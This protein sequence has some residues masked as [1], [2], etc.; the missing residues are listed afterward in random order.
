LQFALSGN[1]AD[2][3]PSL[4][5]MLYVGVSAGSIATTPCHCDVDWDLQWVPPVSDMALRG[6]RAI[7]LVDFA[8]WVHLDNPD[9]M[10]EDNSMA[11]IERWAAGVPMSNHAID[12]ATALKVSGATVEVVSEGHWRLFTFTASTD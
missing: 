7:G 6:E 9:P 8:L 4:E 2:L 11:N 12:G 10:F 1:L 3:L 5:N